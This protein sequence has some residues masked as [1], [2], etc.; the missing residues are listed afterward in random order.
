M[1]LFGM[2]LMQGCGL[3]RCVCCIAGVASG[4][5]AGY[6]VAFWAPG[7]AQRL[8]VGCGRVALIDSVSGVRL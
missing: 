4:V 3:S 8:S 6:Q 1:A 7:F 5:A 2:G